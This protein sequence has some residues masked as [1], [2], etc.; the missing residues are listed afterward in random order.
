[1]NRAIIDISMDLP[2]PEPEEDTHALALADRG[3]GI[4]RAHPE[5]KLTAEPLTGMGG[6]RRGAN[7]I[8]RRSLPQRALVIDRLTHGVD[9]P[10]QPRSRRANDRVGILDLGPAADT[11]A[12]E[13]TKRQGQG[14]AIAEANNLAADPLA[15]A[16]LQMNPIADRQRPLDAANLHHHAEH[17]GDPAIKPKLGQFIDLGR[18][19]ADDARHGRGSLARRSGTSCEITSLLQRPWT[20]LYH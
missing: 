14:P 13:P 16:A 10:A 1:V 3:E 9:H 17:G 18:Q 19:I 7:R 4:D 20:G 6:R 11:D 12:L 2:T 8:R 5:I 15:T